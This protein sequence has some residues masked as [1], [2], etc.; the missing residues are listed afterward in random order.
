MSTRQKTRRS[1]EE[2]SRLVAA[3]RAS[4][5]TSRVFAARHQLNAGTLLYWSYRLSKASKRPRPAK[6]TKVANFVEVQ[7]AEFAAPS[8]HENIATT[9]SGGTMEVVTRSGR[10]IRWE[11]SMNVDAFRTMLKVVESC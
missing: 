2:W 5:E 8:K 1:A 11:G 4:G 10:I 3:W 9:A 7:V 6:S